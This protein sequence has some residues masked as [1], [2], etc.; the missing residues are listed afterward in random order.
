MGCSSSSEGASAKRRV[1]GKRLEP[2]EVPVPPSSPTNRGSH[3]SGV[4][5]VT[6]CSCSGSFARAA[7]TAS[8]PRSDATW[9]PAELACD[10]SSSAADGPSVVGADLDIETIESDGGFT[11]CPHC[12]DDDCY[13]YEDDD[14]CLQQQGTFTYDGTVAAANTLWSLPTFA[15]LTEAQ[16]MV[17]SPSSASF[18]PHGSPSG[19]SASGDGSPGMSVGAASSG[20]LFPMRKSVS[21][22]MRPT[23][24]TVVPPCASPR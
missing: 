22:R 7:S 20:S 23:K 19:T 2:I 14:D 10:V 17:H 4:Y 6:S 16:S 13:A 1:F 9:A 12:G 21:F 8:S 3:G 5:R 11:G 18:A 15:V 24:V